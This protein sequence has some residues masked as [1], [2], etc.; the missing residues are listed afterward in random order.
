MYIYSRAKTLYLGVDPPF[1]YKTTVT[2][3]GMIST[4]P[5]GFLWGLINSKYFNHCK[6]HRGGFS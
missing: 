5:S 3:S 1:T 4:R 6:L 2:R